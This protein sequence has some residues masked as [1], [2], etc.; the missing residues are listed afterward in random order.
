MA[1][2]NFILKSFKFGVR[3]IN[4]CK[5]LF[6]DPL[7]KLL[8]LTY[9]RVLRDSRFNPFCMVVEEG[10]FIE[11]LDDLAKRLRIVSL[12][13]ALSS[14]KPVSDNPKVQ[15]VLTFDDGYRDNYETVFPILKKKGLPAAFFIVT[16]F[17]GGD[18]PLWDWELMAILNNDKKINTIEINGK[19]L[20]KK[21][22]ETASS[23]F[24]RVFCEMKVLDGNSIRGIIDSL[25][26]S[27]SGA[28]SRDC[29]QSGFM[30]W[31][32]IR[33]M[34]DAGMEIGAHSLSHRSLSG[35]PIN[36]AMHEIKSS[37]EIIEEKIGRSCE[38]FSFPFGSKR[39]FNDTLIDCV[40]SAGFRS[41]LSNVHGYNHTEKGVFCLKR[42]IME[43]MS[44]VKY[45][46]G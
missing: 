19:L 35:L 13:E 37:K 10:I 41:C 29:A 18:R 43:E 25:K 16:D 2:R 12:S 1:S 5:N 27:S 4:H 21:K 7:P 31:E 34:G 6:T 3:R 9:H 14:H 11:Q 44:N 17:L 33:E 24:Y 39:D 30:T 15:A 36:E 28:S 8:I 38:H 22:W 32:Q 20:S 46:L 45:L 26:G 42:V 40:R 23:F